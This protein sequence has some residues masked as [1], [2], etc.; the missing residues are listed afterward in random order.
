MENDETLLMVGAVNDDDLYYISE[1][2][3]RIVNVD[4][5]DE[6]IYVA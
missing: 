1:C 5:S 6:G 2:D 4:E 3:I